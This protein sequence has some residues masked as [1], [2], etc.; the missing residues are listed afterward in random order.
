MSSNWISDA[1]A[2]LASGA[3]DSADVIDVHAPAVLDA[4]G[5]RALIAPFLAGFMWAAVVFRELQTHATLDPMALLFRVL[6]LALTLRAI[7]VLYGLARRQRLAHRRRRY[8]L[9]LTD[10]G[11]LFRSPDGGDVVVPKDEIIDVREHG[12]TALSSRRSLRWAEVYVV[13][14]PESPR[15]YV[16]LPPIFGRG[17][18]ALAE[19]LMRWRGG[20]AVAPLTAATE[21]APTLPSKLWEQAAAGERAPG[22][23]A[24]KH[25]SAWLKRGPYASLLLG[26][27]VLDGYVRMSP[28]EQRALN[29]TPALLLAAALVVVPLGWVLLSRLNMAARRGLALVITPRELLVR[30]RSGVTRIAWPDVTRCEVASRMSWSLLQGTYEARSLVVTRKRESAVQCNEAFLSVPAEV[31]AAVCEFYRKNSADAVAADTP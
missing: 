7:R 4:E 26:L 15:L 11:L 21:A 13:T 20:L 31:V 6:A 16:S 12:A 8:A 23:L 2:A 30:V 14:H 29:P 25:G 18:R 5:A 9:V 19:L 22:V 3:S 28:A 27:A 1:E 10:E 17:P 24:I